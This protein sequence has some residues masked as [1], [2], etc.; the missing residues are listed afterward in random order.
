MQQLH[1]KCSRNV[2][3]VKLSAF[4]KFAFLPRNTLKSDIMKC[5]YTM[6]QDVTKIALTTPLKIC[7]K[8]VYSPLVLKIFISQLL[9]F[10]SQNN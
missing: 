2:S 7:L 10:S 6:I 4:I 5:A 1:D 9:R 8:M 3:L